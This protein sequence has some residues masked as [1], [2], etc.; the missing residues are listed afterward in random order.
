M[1]NV[2]AWAIVI[3][4]GDGS[5]DVNGPY[6]D[7]EAAIIAA[8]SLAIDLATDEDRAWQA[9]PNGALVHQADLK[10]ALDPESIHLLVRAMGAAIEPGV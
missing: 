6:D 4:W 2:S 8:R 5:V 3:K 10:P 9:T 1:S 7:E